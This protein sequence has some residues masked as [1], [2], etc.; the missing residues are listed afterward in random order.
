[1]SLEKSIVD[2]AINLLSQKLLAMIEENGAFTYRFNLNPKVKV[3]E[4]YNWLRHYGALFSLCQAASNP[5]S[6]DQTQS[7]L[8]GFDYAKEKCIAP[9]VGIPNSLGVWS[10]P[11]IEPTVSA[12]AIKLGGVGLALVAYCEANKA[13]V[14]QADLNL[15]TQLAN[16]LEHMQREDGGFH[17]KYFKE[18]GA[19]SEWVSLYYPGEAALGLTELFLISK[20]ARWLEIAQN[21]LLYLEKSRRGQSSVP[22]DHWALIATGR[23][24]KLVDEET[25]HLLHAHLAAVV[26]SI[27]SEQ[28]TGTNTIADG[29]FTPD[30]R[31]TPTSTRLEGL[32]AAYPIIDDARL[33]SKTRAAIELGM[34]FLASA[35]EGS[36]PQSGAFPRAIATINSNHPDAPKFNKRATEVR[37]DY[38]QHALSAFIG[39]RQL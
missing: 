3:P 22:A 10:R 8:N 7:I 33:A 38:I 24:W 39:Y 9:V 29:C 28:V 15:L 13:G 14:I 23:I 4:R 12:E 26:K 6:M 21:S 18:G 30:G 35:V 25:Q 36:G 2:R 17:S 16:F 32:I 19:S 20:D 37:I 27:L 5:P 1:M 34:E 11:E 31:T